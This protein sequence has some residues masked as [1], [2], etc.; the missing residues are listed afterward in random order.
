[1]IRTRA[2]VTAATALVALLAVSSSVDAQRRRHGGATEPPQPSAEQREAARTAYASGQELFRAGSFAEA[3]AQ[4]EA[5]F[6]AIPNPVV[7]LSVA[8]CQERQN[9][10]PDA[11]A[12]LERYLAARADAPDRAAIEQRVAGLRARPATL[13]VS[14]TPSGAAVSVDGQDTGRTTPAEVT[15]A[16]G[17][18]TIALT[19]AGYE[20][21]S[22]HVSVTFGV[23]Q[24]VSA[25]LTATPGGSSEDEIFGSGGTHEGEG[26]GEP[27]PPPP[28]PSHG[29]GAPVWIAAGVGG[30]ALVTGTV[31]GFLALDKQSEFNAMPT[32][33]A[34]DDGKML[35]LFA[36]VGFGVAA[37]GIITAIV[38]YATS[39]AADEDSAEPEPEGGSSDEPSGEGGEGGSTEPTARHRQR[40]PSLSFAPVVGPTA[41]GI[42]AGV[43]F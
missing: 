38:L 20:A 5:A 15:V 29:V 8:E 18:H 3:Q 21:G 6:T 12:T 10:V 34:A 27:P 13:A 33:A 14:S 26:E 24:E 11:V 43:R 32:Q 30:A 36:D 17:D 4:F 42:V 2:F 31:L 19:L 40:G 22:E 25:T 35:A 23:R 39:D 37:A 7:L 41:A 1:M 28:P 16:P 9:L